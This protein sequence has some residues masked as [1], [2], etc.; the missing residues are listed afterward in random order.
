M[1][2]V[3]SVVDSSEDA[4]FFEKISPRVR[5]SSFDSATIEKNVRYRE[6][7]SDAHDQ[8]MQKAFFFPLQIYRLTKT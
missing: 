2:R 1:S 3:A 7:E 8:S 5:P 4:W 6:F